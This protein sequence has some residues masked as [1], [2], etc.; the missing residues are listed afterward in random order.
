MSQEQPSPE[1][2]FSQ[3]EISAGS[4]SQPENQSGDN[5][6]TVQL[7]KVM[8][9]QIQRQTQLLEEL[10]RQQNVNQKQRANELGQWKKAHPELA[11]RCRHA[12]EALSRV[13][14]SYLDTLTEDVMYNSESLEDGEFMLTEFVDRFGPRLAHLN[15]MLQVLS[16]L[17][18]PSQ[19]S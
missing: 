15:G 1:S 17:S 14:V 4:V 6:E 13:Q 11:E 12:A 2:F 7:L 9:K 5:P 18:G 16:Q 10:V 8:T 19:S 3:V